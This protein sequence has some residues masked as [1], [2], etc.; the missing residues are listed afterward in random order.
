MSSDVDEIPVYGGS[1]PAPNVQEIVKNNP[2]S[3]PER[4]IR[5]PEDMPQ[6]CINTIPSSDIPQIDFSRILERCAEEL[7]KLDKACEEWG[8]F[9]VREKNVKK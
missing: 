9:Q 6:T 3:V 4:Y 8:F 1:L 5:S 7:K 2:S